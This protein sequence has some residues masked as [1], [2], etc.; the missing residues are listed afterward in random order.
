MNIALRRNLFIMRKNYFINIIFMIFS[1]P[2]W[3]VTSNP[4][5]SLNLT[6]PLMTYTSVHIMEQLEDYYKY[7]GILNSLP[8]N[9]NEIVKAKFESVLMIYIINT[10]LTLLTHFIYSVLGV[11]E[12]ITGEMFLLG[13]SLSFLISMI[14]GAV[15]IALISKF[16]YEKSKLFG[17]IAMVIIMSTISIPLFIL[18]GSILIP[19]ISLILMALGITAYVISLKLTLKIY[20]EKEF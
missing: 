19:V 16:G 18:K 2:L 13:L 10:V 1:I 3:T 9:R 8:I 12:F 7:D 20:S 17:I 6:I 11:T 5:G 14:F 15:G 4:L